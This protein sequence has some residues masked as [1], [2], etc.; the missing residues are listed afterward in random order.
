VTDPL[1]SPFWFRHLQHSDV[2]V[3]PLRRKGG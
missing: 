3:S 1:R 2:G